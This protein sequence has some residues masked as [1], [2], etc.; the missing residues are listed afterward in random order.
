MAQ[1]KSSANL[2]L[3]AL[4]EVKI[5]SSRLRFLFGRG[6]MDKEDVDEDDEEDVDE[7]VDA[8]DGNEEEDV[9]MFDDEG[10]NEAVELDDD[11]DDSDD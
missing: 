5:Q 2:P 11:S 6:T 9:D 3:M 7:A 10:D 8:F 1:L 4:T